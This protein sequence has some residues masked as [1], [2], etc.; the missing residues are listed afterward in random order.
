[1]LPQRKTILAKFNTFYYNSC[2][3]QNEPYLLQFFHLLSG[4]A[5]AKF[6]EKA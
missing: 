4:A 5:L 3:L 1:M 6:V 2:K